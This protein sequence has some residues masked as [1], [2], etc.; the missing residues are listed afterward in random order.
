M[1]GATPDCMGIKPRVCAVLCGAHDAP[2]FDESTDEIRDMLTAFDQ[3]VDQERL[4]VRT[5]TG[6]NERLFW[7]WLLWWAGADTLCQVAHH[8]ALLCGRATH[9]NPL[10]GV[11]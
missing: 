5:A 3:R 1:I 10:T 9:R 4:Q 2:E 8:F 6:A 7:A 11:V